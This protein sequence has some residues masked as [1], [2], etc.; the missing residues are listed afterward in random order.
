MKGSRLAADEWW[1][2]RSRRVPG[3]SRNLGTRFRVGHVLMSRQLHPLVAT[4]KK[5]YLDELLTWMN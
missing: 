4:I 2:E 5:N 1:A 3:A